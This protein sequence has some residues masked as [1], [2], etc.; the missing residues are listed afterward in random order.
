MVPLREPQ[1]FFCPKK[2]VTTKEVKGKEPTH[3]KKALKRCGH[4]NWS[5][6]RKKRNTQENK[7]KLEGRGKVSVLYIKKISENIAKVFKRHHIETIHKPSAM[8]E[9]FFATK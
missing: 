6:N 8:L 1:N 9:I 7:E 3:V 5:L 2:L 4:P